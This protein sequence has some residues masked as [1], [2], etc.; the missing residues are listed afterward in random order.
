[1]RVTAENA[2]LAVVRVRH[3]SGFHAFL[4]SVLQLSAARTALPVRRES[5]FYAFLLSVLKLSAARAALP[6]RHELG[7]YAFLLSVLQMGSAFAELPVRYESG[8]HAFYFSVLQIVLVSDLPHLKKALEMFSYGSQT[9]IVSNKHVA[10]YP[11]KCCKL[12]EQTG[13]D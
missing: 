2:A 6:V 1:L 8:F 13:N 10:N 3:E 9:R 7:F 5:G 11:R 12:I 4:L